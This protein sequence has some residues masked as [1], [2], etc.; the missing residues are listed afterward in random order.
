MDLSNLKFDIIIQGGQSNA[1]GYGIGDVLE[2]YQPNPNILYLQEDRQIEHTDKGLLIAH[3]Q[4]LLSVQIANEKKENDKKIGDFSLTFAEEYVKNGLLKAD[5]K[6]LIIRAAVGGTGFARGHW[7]RFDYLYLRM[8]RM[9][10]Y[11][12]SLNPENRVVAFLWHQGEHEV[13][14]K[15]DPE[16]YYRQLVSMI[17]EVRQICKWDIPFLVGDFVSDWKTANWA[18]CEPIVETIRRVV[19]NVGNAIFVETED[20]PSNDQK[21]KN[22]DTIHFCREA[23][24]ILGK[25]Y[26]SLYEKLKESL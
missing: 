15:N 8:L 21:T 19:K 7:G 1:Q 11:A 20:L 26:F 25:R 5:R 22:G 13:I 24:H 17:E 16:N 23:L 10:E 4:S 18:G 9:V 2:E 3:K 6:L 14:F 12:L